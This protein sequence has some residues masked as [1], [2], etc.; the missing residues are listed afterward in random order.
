MNG[1]GGSLFGA[2]RGST[3][4]IGRQPFG[5]TTSSLGFNVQAAASQA[6]SQVGG[7]AGAIARG[8]QE[9]GGKLILGLARGNSRGASNGRD[10][11]RNSSN[12]ENFD[13]TSQENSQM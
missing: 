5:Q 11:Y 2:S 7:G 6:L 1:A 9:G 8:S 3:G 10:R 4:N 13:A 12:A